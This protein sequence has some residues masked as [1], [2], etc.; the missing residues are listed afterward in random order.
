M[1]LRQA[2]V[3]DCAVRIRHLLGTSRQPF[4]LI[5]R[6]LTFAYVTAINKNYGKKKIEE[7]MY[8]IIIY[9]ISF[10][11]DVWNQQV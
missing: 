8:V 11:R 7:K 6:K 3:L 10:G 9:S 2:E 5:N 4:Q 1:R